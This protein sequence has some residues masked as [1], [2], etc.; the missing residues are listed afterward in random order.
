ML[1]VAKILWKLQFGEQ[2]LKAGEKELSNLRTFSM[3]QAQ[4]GKKHT[5]KTP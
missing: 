1:S 3:A 5:K 2:S 4:E